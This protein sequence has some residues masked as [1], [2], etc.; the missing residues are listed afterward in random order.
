MGA[1]AV[2]G[3]EFHHGDEKDESTHLSGLAVRYADHR[4]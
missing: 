1:D 3:V 4:P 2:I